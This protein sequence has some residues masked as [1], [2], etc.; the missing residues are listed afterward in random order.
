MNEPVDRETGAPLIT[1]RLSI[2]EARWL[3]TA[4]TIAQRL[5]E[6]LHLRGHEGQHYQIRGLAALHRIADQLPSGLVGYYPRSDAFEE[7]E[8]SAS[9]STSPEEPFE[10]ACHTQLRGRE[11]SRRSDRSPIND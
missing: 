10:R 2:D 11:P 5:L 6:G 4:V 3:V 7:P 1:L 8:P 9:L